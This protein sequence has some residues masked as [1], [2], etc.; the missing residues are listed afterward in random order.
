MR[1]Y[2]PE[3]L[4]AVLAAVFERAV[5]DVRTFRSYTAACW[6]NG[7]Q[8]SEIATIIAGVDPEQY[9]AWAKKMLRSVR[10][11]NVRTHTRKL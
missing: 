5:L 7:R 9:D 1:Q 2:P 8:A 3:R 6:L 11:A 10:R 4:D